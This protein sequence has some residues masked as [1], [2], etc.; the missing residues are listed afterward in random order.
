MLTL[1]KLQREGESISCSRPQM[2]PMRGS[3]VI[4][5]AQACNHVRAGLVCGVPDKSSLANSTYHHARSGRRARSG[6]RC[7]EFMYYRTKISEFLA[8]SSVK[9]S[10]LLGKICSIMSPFSSAPHFG[11]N[12]EH[13]DGSCEIHAL[14]G[15]KHL[16]HCIGGI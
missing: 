1:L 8:T 10:T 16:H 2:T 14:C 4:E 5:P 7:C 9:T 15:T 13:L 11:L 3:T 6:T 12:L